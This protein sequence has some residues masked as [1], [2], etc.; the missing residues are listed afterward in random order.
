MIAEHH[1]RLILR[2]VAGLK[3]Q[4]ESYPDESAI[5]DRSGGIGNPPGNLGL[6]VA[7]NLR[8]FV[9]HVLGGI[10]YVRDRDAEFS[11]RDVPLAEILADLDAA[12]AAVDST[13]RNV[14]EDR[15]SEPFPMKFGDVE[16]NTGR[17]LTHLCSHLAYHL[18][19]V[20]YHRRITTGGPALPGVMGFEGLVD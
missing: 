7:G 6:H 13:L 3:R 10:D 2:D 17:F 8:H 19:Q 11:R 5:W 20:D 9:G 14:P 12:A 1:R 18:G 15:L 16:L 4:L